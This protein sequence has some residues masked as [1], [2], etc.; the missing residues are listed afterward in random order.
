MLSLL[1][2]ITFKNKKKYVLKIFY[3]VFL[4]TTTAFLIKKFLYRFI[5]TETYP[6]HEQILPYQ[7]SK[8]LSV[9]T[10]IP[11]HPI[12]AHPYYLSYRIDT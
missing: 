1:L 10:H 8:L 5:Q 3:S 12:P 4:H 11:T 7:N 6:H 9:D 2:N